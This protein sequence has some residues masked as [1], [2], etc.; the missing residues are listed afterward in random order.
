MK[1][2]REQQDLQ[3]DP[4]TEGS[5]QHGVM[6]TATQSMGARAALHHPT[7]SAVAMGHEGPSPV[8]PCAGSRPGIFC[9]P[10]TSRF[11]GR[12]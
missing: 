6:L 8:S 2:E 11:S 12:R 3:S 9:R 1:A 5:L 7:V 10:D 4:L